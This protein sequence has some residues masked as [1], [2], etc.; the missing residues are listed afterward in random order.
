MKIEY[1]L[2]NLNK[3]L[4]NC[5]CRTKYN[6]NLVPAPRATRMLPN[7]RCVPAS[8]FIT[9]LNLWQRQICQSVANK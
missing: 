9:Q 5:E 7:G 2:K 4:G 8:Q 3:F 6:S 1:S